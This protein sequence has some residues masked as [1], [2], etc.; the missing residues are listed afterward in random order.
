MPNPDGTFR[1]FEKISRHLNALRARACTWSGSARDSML[2]EI[3]EVEEDVVRLKAAVESANR[4]APG[5]RTS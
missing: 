5:H 3:V 2:N 1:R 4:T